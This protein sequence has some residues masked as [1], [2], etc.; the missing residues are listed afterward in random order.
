MVKK[1]FEKIGQNLQENSISQVYNFFSWA[2]TEHLKNTFLDLCQLHTYI[3]KM[4]SKSFNVAIRYKRLKVVEIAIF[5]K[6]E[7]IALINLKI[8]SCIN[9]FQWSFQ[10]VYN[11]HKCTKYIF[12][13]FI[14]DPDKRIVK[15][16]IVIYY[17]LRDSDYFQVIQ[18]C[19]F[20]SSS[21]L[22]RLISQWVTVF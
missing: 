1:N 20:T 3:L 11:W 7:P 12:Q 14:T 17:F 15:L 19:F 13:I 22:I 6:F 10:Y 16:T 21:K 2:C 9:R 18:N 4:S 5:H 8:F